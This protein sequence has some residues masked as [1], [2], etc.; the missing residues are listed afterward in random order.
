MEK[1]EVCSV[2]PQCDM[3]VTW[4]ICLPQNHTATVIIVTWV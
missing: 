4:K 2:L 3:D 1:T